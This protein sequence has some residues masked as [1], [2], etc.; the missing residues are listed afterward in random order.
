MSTISSTLPTASTSSTSSTSSAAGGWASLQPSDFIQMMVTQLQNQDPTQPTSNEDILQQISQIGQLQSADT[1]QTD[2]STMVLQ[3]S[4][5]SA[6]NLIG[7]SVQGVDTTGATSS[8]LVNSVQV[9]NG[10][11][12]LQLDSGKQMLLSNVQ[13]ITAPAAST[14]AAGTTTGIT[15]NTGTTPGTTSSTAGTTASQ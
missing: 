2:L 5:S 7:K 8:G 3:N 13:N 10:S 6:G 15:T 4:I 14:S 11:V 12:Y 1:L 9:Q